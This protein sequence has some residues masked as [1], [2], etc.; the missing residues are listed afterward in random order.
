[1][2]SVVE[3]II[4]MIKRYGPYFCIVVD[5][6]PFDKV[7]GGF[8]PFVVIPYLSCRGVKNTS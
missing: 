8:A 7:P 4:Y 1:M 2:M 6:K 5:K 3:I